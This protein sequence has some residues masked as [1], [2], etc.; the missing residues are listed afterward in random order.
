MDNDLIDGDFIVRLIKEASGLDGEIKDYKITLNIKSVPP[1]FNLNL[2][3]L[4][5]FNTRKNRE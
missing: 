2:R 5:D 3:K 1:K 4:L